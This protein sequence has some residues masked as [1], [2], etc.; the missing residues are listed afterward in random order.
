LRAHS[1]MVSARLIT[2]QDA[3]DKATRDNAAL[4]DQLRAK[5]EELLRVKREGTTEIEA[6]H[7]QLTQLDEPVQAVV[8]GEIISLD[9]F[10]ARVTQLKSVTSREQ[11]T[12]STSGATDKSAAKDKKD[13]KPEIKDRKPRVTKKR[14]LTSLFP[15]EEV[16]DDTSKRIS[17]QVTKL[18]VMEEN[19]E[20][21]IDVLS[22]ALPHIVSGVI[23]KKREELIP[24]L[25]MAIRFHPVEE[26]RTQ[27]TQLLFNLVKIPTE[28]QRKSILDGW[29]WLAHL[30]GPDRVAQELLPSCWEQ[31]NNK[32]AER[33]VLVA[34]CAG[35]LGNA[36]TAE[37]RA[38]LLVSIV[39]SLL[40][41]T[42]ASVRRSATANLARLLLPRPDDIDAARVDEKKYKDLRDLLMKAL[43]D[44]D[45]EVKNIARQVLLPVFTD[46]VEREE[47]LFPK[48]ANSLLEGIGAIV[49]VSIFSR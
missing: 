1:T 30:Q 37:M 17:E 26:K 32:Y 21:V 24:V 4:K 18:R 49:N 44:N 16:G 43:H 7:A 11:T 40:S 23:L 2:A 29:E 33:R 20:S 27:L 8:R 28:H 13:S 35:R 34:E 10:K 48:F 47:Y 36:V 41:D 5:E 6:L 9:E 46:W 15:R 19:R 14:D 12:A 39:T 42:E 25:L 45:V 22:T 38:S 31:I 3:L